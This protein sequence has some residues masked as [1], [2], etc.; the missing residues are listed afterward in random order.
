MNEEVK[1]KEED[2]P[3]TYIIE[4]E[5]NQRL[6]IGDKIHFKYNGEMIAQFIYKDSKTS[7]IEKLT[8]IPMDY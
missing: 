8:L 5:P 6:K 3:I 1:M 4:I 2:K 7:C